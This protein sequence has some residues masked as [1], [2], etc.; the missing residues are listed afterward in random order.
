M[1]AAPGP[2]TLDPMN[3]AFPDLSPL[4]SL[5]QLGI[6]GH[7]TGGTAPAFLSS[8]Y[9][10]AHLCDRHP[11]LFLARISISTPCPCFLS[12]HSNSRDLTLENLQFI[13]VS[14]SLCNTT[15][16]TSLCASSIHDPPHSHI[17]L[18]QGSVFPPNGLPRCFYSLPSLM[19]L[20]GSN[21]SPPSLPSIH[22]RQ[23]TQR[24]QPQKLLHVHSEQY[25]E[26]PV[27]STAFSLF[28]L[29]F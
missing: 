8:L 20:Y 21:R 13:D 18:L 1:K 24:H 25:D 3:P 15:G 29:P 7:M 6:T 10:L 28:L 19:Y 4:T 16:L 9:N 14:A 27:R 5:T 17:R 12:A 11:F 22:V 2:E 23:G 26:A